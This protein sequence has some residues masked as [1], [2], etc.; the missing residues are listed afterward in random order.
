MSKIIIVNENDE[1]IGAKERES[2]VSDDIYRVSALW[3]TNSKGDILLAQR[4][5]TKSHDPGKWGP[6][7]AG[8]VEEGEDH[9]S[10]IIKEAE[11]ELGLKNV[12]FIKVDKVRIK[13]RHNY[14]TQWYKAVIDRGVDDFKIQKE[15]VEQIKWFS[16][17]ELE[18]EL[19]KNPEK[20]LSGIKDYLRMFS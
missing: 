12:D 19:A 2:L 9:D 14:F 3:I 6:A 18:S 16:H 20:F 11:E 1:I 8:T 13:T 4:A 10:N 5:F 17:V 15:E 7:V